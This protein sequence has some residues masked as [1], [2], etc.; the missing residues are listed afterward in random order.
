MDDLTEDGRCETRLQ[1]CTRGTR[2]IAEIIG[3]VLENGVCLPDY[4]LNL[5]IACS[6]VSGLSTRIAH[7]KCP[8]I[9]S[10]PN[11]LTQ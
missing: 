9:V 7:N 2:A 8:E 11:K 5:E 3:V 4:S 6:R 1:K 10:V